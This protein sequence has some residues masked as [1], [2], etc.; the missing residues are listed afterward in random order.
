MGCGT[1]DNQTT[2]IPVAQDNPS[3]TELPSTNVKINTKDSKGNKNAKGSSLRKTNV[4]ADA[5]PSKHDIRASQSGAKKND[6]LRGSSIRESTRS[7]GK[8]LDV[9]PSKVKLNVE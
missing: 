8:G 6:S 2:I 4:K 3:G 9:S 1:S 7:L 5:T